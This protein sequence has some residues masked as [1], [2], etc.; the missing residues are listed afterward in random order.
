MFRMRNCFL[1]QV[2]VPWGLRKLLI[3]IKEKY[4]NVP[5]FITEN[6]FADNGEINDIGRSK[7]IVVSSTTFFHTGIS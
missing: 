5:V 6:G 1:L 4:Q 3:W 7:C 2:T